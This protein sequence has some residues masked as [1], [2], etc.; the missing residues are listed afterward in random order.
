MIE[1]LKIQ[2][3]NLLQDSH[4]LVEVVVLHDLKKKSKFIKISNFLKFYINLFLFSNFR[5]PYR[6]GVDGGERRA[7]LL[8]VRVVLAEKNFR[9]IFL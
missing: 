1:K 8:H 6:S 3:K 5:L 4:G 2:R 7:H 9:L